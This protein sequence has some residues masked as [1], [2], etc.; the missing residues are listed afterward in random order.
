MDADGNLKLADFGL[1]NLMA[2]GLFLRTSCGSPN[3][4]APEIFLDLDYS[5]AEVDIWSSGV[6]L[7]VLLSGSLPF[8]DDK[9]PELIKK[10]KNAQYR[11]PN[12]VS[13]P[14]QDLI[15]QILQVDP[16]ARPDVHA[17]KT[18]AFFAA[19]VPP[20]ISDPEFLYES[21]VHEVIDEDIVSEILTFNYSRE[22]VLA[23][24]QAESEQKNDHVVEDHLNEQRIVRVTYKI[25]SDDKKRKKKKPRKIVSYLEI[26]DEQKRNSQSSGATNVSPYKLVRNNSVSPPGKT[27]VEHFRENPVRNWKVAFDFRVK[28]YED[29]AEVMVKI[30]KVLQ[31]MKDI[32][33]KL[34]T[35]RKEEFRVQVRLFEE[36]HKPWDESKIQSS[37]KK[38]VSSGSI[39]LYQKGNE[40]E[41]FEVDFQHA[42]GNIF[43]FM[44]RMWLIHDKLS[45]M[46]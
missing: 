10:I 4:A 33:W 37:P 7:F 19:D 27:L 30:L 26:L 12:F 34:G 9:L 17:I 42:T 31:I 24:I 20:Y 25:L 16:I 35:A 36:E 41:L 39:Q 21:E 13:A 46:R 38:C 1:S 22:T 2:D 40:E 23:A 28:N 18:H 6:I 11:I 14:A 15:A 44:R 5:G 29:G 32:E 3:Y 45:R 43:V 8:D